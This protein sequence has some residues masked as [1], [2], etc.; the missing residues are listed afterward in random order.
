MILNNSKTCDCLFEI[1]YKKADSSGSVS[2]ELLADSSI[3]FCQY[4][5]ETAGAK[6]KA[7]SHF[8]NFIC[9]SQNFSKSPIF[10]YKLASFSSLSFSLFLES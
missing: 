4:S 1:I 6:D 5:Y 8:P 3:N 9:I 2:R 7:F 10:K